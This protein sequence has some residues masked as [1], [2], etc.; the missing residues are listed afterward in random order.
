LKVSSLIDL[1]E[2]AESE[3]HS[4][5]NEL[6]GGAR[7]KRQTRKLLSRTSF[8]RLQGAFIQGSSQ[9]R[10]LVL[11]AIKPETRRRRFPPTDSLAN[12]SMSHLFQGARSSHQTLT[13]FSTGGLRYDPGVS[14]PTSRRLGQLVSSTARKAL[15]T[16]PMTE[17]KKIAAVAKSNPATIFF[18]LRATPRRA[19][20]LGG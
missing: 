4:L 1:L 3:E 16:P 19:A 15:L 9:L 20:G 2:T 13:G 18:L 12:Q 6:C 5:L 10:E 17:A 14:H 7:E 11:H 8:H